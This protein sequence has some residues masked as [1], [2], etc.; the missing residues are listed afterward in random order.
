MTTATS[1][2]A[3]SLWLEFEEYTDGDPQPGNDPTCDFCNAIVRMNGKAYGSDIWTFGFIDDTR[4]HDAFTGVPKPEIER[5]LLPP[6]LP[7][8]RLDRTLIE[9]AIACQLQRHPPSPVQWRWHEENE[10]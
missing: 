1:P 2:A 4:R 10:T 7:V 9:E 6:D 8:E 5:H 3:F